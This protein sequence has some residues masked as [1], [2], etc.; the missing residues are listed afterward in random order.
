MILKI[1]PDK[2]WFSQIYTLVVQQLNLQL[3][4]AIPVFAA[5]LTSI[6]KINS[7]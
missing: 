6:Q 4:P 1:I 3:Q 2:P 7:T 5:R